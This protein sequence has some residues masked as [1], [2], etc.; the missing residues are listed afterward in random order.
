MTAI[1]SPALL[2]SLESIDNI[3]RTVVTRPK[4]LFWTFLVSHELLI[5]GPCDPD[6][7]NKTIVDELSRSPKIARLV[8]VTIYIARLNTVPVRYWQRPIIL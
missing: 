7:N 6:L 3:I 8:S 4:F 5:I 2:S 1:L